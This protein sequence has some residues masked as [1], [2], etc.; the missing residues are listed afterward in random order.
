[1][2]IDKI[3]K[4]NKAELLAY[5]TDRASEFLTD[6]KQKYAETQSDKLEQEV[7]DDFKNLYGF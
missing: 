7:F 1:M 6:I 5:F 4:D 2:I 3:L